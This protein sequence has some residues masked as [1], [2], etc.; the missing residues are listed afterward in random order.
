MSQPLMNIQPEMVTIIGTGTGDGGTPLSTGVLA[1]TPDHLPNLVLRVISP[2]LAIIVRAIVA[3]LTAASG[4]LTAAGL[5]GSKLFGASDLHGILVIAA[6]TGVCAAIPVTAKNLLTI[7]A[8]L[9]GKFP[10]WTGTV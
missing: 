3:F 10:L 8:G 2:A 5:G 7:F 4:V 6:W 1:Q 9:E